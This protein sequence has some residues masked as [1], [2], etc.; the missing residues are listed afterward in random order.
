[1]KIYL[2]TEVFMVQDRSAG[3]RDTWEFLDRRLE[4]F[5]AMSG[6]ASSLGILASLGT[7]AQAIASIFSPENLHRDDSSMKE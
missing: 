6:D 2:S 7:G 4:D 1:M 5:N 3:H